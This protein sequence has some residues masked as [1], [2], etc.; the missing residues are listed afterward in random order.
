MAQRNTRA[1]D[2]KSG[3]NEALKQYLLAQCERQRLKGQMLGGEGQGEEHHHLG[4]ELEGWGAGVEAMRQELARALSTTASIMLCL[5][6]PMR[7]SVGSITG[8]SDANKDKA[9]RTHVE[10]YSTSGSMPAMQAKVLIFRVQPGGKQAFF[11][12]F[13]PLSGVPKKQ[14]RRDSLG[15]YLV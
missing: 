13:L 7:Y 12:Q 1:I 15:P 4:L 9:W 2:S 5:G 14:R 6:V 11:G 3:V 10:L 8:S